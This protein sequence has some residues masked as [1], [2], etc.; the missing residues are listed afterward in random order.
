MESIVRDMPDGA[1]KHPP[2]P[3]ARSIDELE[4]LEYSASSPRQYQFCH[5]P[6][7][8]R[9]FRDLYR[10]MDETAFRLGFRRLYLHTLYSVPDRCSGQRLTDCH[11]RDAF[12]SL[13]SPATAAAANR[14]I[15]RWYYGSVPYD[16]SWL[17]TGPVQPDIPSI[18]GRM[19][20]AYV[21]TVSYGPA[22]STIMLEPDQ[23]LRPRL[24]L[25]YSF[26]N[27][28]GLRNLPIEVAHYFDDGF[29]F[30]RTSEALYLPSNSSNATH[31]M[32]LPYEVRE[33]R[34]WIYVYAGDR[35]LA[36][37][38]FEVIPTTQ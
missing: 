5:T 17:D 16:L 18:D 33:G 38:T 10:N 36:E 35:K 8:E 9:L 25:K 30:L 3:F 28:D 29:E 31:R 23:R 21:S 32:R 2:C 26:T 1:M 27:P 15:D 13:A 34:Y 24:N 7:G 4:E 14:V 20:D 22:V 37:V 6:L 12:A 11:L 19:N